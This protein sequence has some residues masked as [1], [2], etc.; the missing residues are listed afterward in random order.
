ME[1]FGIGLRKPHVGSIK[2]DR[3]KGLWELRAKQGS[4]ITRIFYF[5]PYEK[6]FILLHGFVKKDDKT[7]KRELETALSRM[8]DW[9]RRF[10]K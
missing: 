3:Y 6:K 4:D 2:G 9:K 1:E 5:L 8:K 7:P 10:M